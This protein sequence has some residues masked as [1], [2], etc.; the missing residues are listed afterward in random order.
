MLLIRRLN[1][2]RGCHHVPLHMLRIGTRCQDVWGTGDL[3]LVFDGA[4]RHGSGGSA[5]S[6]VGLKVLFIKRNG[7][8]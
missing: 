2:K 6:A 1:M 7:K 8:T 4:V 3:R 5:L